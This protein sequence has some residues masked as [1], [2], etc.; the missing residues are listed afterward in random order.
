MNFRLRN[1]PTYL[2]GSVAGAA[3]HPS[4]KPG[5][6]ANGRQ[7]G[8]VTTGACSSCW[9]WGSKRARPSAFCVALGA[10]CVRWSEPLAAYRSREGSRAVHPRQRLEPVASLTQTPAAGSLVLRDRVRDHD[11]Q[12]PAHDPQIGKALKTFKSFRVGLLGLISS[13]SSARS[14]PAV[15]P[16]CPPA[17]WSRRPGS[18]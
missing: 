18:G 12:R 7:A 2:A 1:S 3:F 16:G 13:D 9:S 5:L 15:R 14:R 4:R 11:C 17:R 8:M 6:S 10:G